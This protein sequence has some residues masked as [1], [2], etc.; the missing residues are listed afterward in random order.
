MPQVGRLVPMWIN[1]VTF[2][3]VEAFVE[4]Q[5]EG[6]FACQLS[7]HIDFIGIDRH[8]NQATSKVQ[9]WLICISIIAVLLL[10][11]INSVLARPW[12]FKLKGNQRDT[13]DKKH[14]V[15]FFQ[16]ICIGITNL[17]SH[18]KQVGRKIFFYLLRTTGEWC[19]VHQR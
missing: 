9:Q 16:W 15:N 19:R 4:R 12:V 18:T 6:I 13:I 8:V 3:K 2:A 17:A 14:H 11:M 1:R 7:R 10:T 5:E